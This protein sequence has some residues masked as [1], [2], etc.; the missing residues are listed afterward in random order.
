MLVWIWNLD[1]LCS[2]E[3]RTEHGRKDERVNW[4]EKHARR[5]KRK[6]QDAEHTARGSNHVL[7][8]Y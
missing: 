5:K 2:G 8:G 4:G 7:R 1:E 3:T 6:E